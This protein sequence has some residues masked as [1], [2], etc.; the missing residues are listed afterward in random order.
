[1]PAGS[2]ANFTPVAPPAGVP[3]AAQLAN[4][5][6]DYGWEYVWHCHLL[7]HEENDMMRP[8]VFDVP[9]TVPTAPRLSATT[10]N[11]VTLTWTDPT[12]FNY[13]TGLPA[14]TLGNPMNEIGFRIMRGTGTGGALTQI[15]TALANQTAFTDRTAVGGTTYQ[16]QVVIY[17][18]A[19]STPSSTLRVTAPRLT[20]A[21]TSLPAGQVGTAYSQTLTATGGTLPCTWWVSA[22]ALPGGLTLNTAGV[23]SGTP[24]NSGTFNFTVQAQDARQVTATRPLSITILGTG[25]GLVQQVSATTTSARTLSASLPGS[26]TASNLIVVGLS[27]YTALPA[28]T[29]PVIDNLGNTYS[30][31]SPARVYNGNGWSAIY[32]ATNVKAGSTTVTVTTAATGTQI[33]MVVAEFAGVAAAAPLVTSASAIGVSATPSSGNMTP[34]GTGQLIIGAGTH[35]G[36]TTTTAGAGF[37]MI[38]IATEDSV[39]HQ[40]LAMEYQV[41]AGS[42][43]TPATFRLATSYGWAMNGAIFKLK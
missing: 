19:G 11:G 32:Y 18:A 24:A 2:T 43:A 31:A 34:S 8:I 36:S 4:V 13:A 37:T 38:A 20:I 1:M 6:T 17:N 40:P 30:A 41:L 33:S 42:A 39:T 28:A 10:T 7:G 26:V 27:G 12:P 9:A 3:A 29:S 22:G 5:V 16:Y 23:V 15:G 14:S 35:G 21:T 25:I